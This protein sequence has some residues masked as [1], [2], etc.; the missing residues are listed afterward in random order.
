MCQNVQWCNVTCNYV[1]LS[2]RWPAASL[3]VGLLACSAD[4]RFS[5][6][7]LVVF[8]CACGKRQELLTTPWDLAIPS[9]RF[10]KRGLRVFYPQN[11]GQDA[12]KN[13]GCA[14]RDAHNFLYDAQI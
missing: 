9:Q 1:S 10:V 4:S 5:I 8:Y 11:L 12:Q 14:S 6:Y 7:V 13:E 2:G 3:A